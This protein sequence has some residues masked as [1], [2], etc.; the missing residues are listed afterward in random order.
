MMK[1]RMSELEGY[2]LN[3]PFYYREPLKYIFIKYVY[4][5]YR[6]IRI[7]SGCFFPLAEWQKKIWTL[8]KIAINSKS[9]AAKTTIGDKSSSPHFI[10]EYIEIM[11]LI[12][13]EHIELLPQKIKKFYNKN[14]KQ[15]VIDSFSLNINFFKV[16]NKGAASQQLGSFHIKENSSLFKYIS[17]V[18]F[19]IVN[20]SDSFCCLIVHAF[21]EKNLQEKINKLAVNSIDI[22]FRIAGYEHKKWFQFRKLSYEQV[23]GA[24]YKRQLL[25]EIVKDITWNVCKVIYKSIPDILF[26]SQK[27]LPPYICSICTNIDGNS[28]NEFWNSVGVNSYLCDYMQCYSACIAWRDK[29]APYFIRGERKDEEL[30][31]LNVYTAYN[32]SQTLCLCMIPD[33]IINLIRKNLTKYSKSITILKHKGVRKWLKLKVNMESTMFYLRRFIDEYTIEA[34]SWSFKEFK[35]IKRKN[36]LIYDIFNGI[37]SE[38]EATKSLYNIVS[39]IFKSNVDYRNAKSN[40]HLQKMALIIS[41]LSMFI[42]IMSIIISLLTNENSFE[43]IRKYWSYVEFF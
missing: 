15:G 6:K 42:A 16:F 25:D 24:T 39:E 43:F 9:N 23:S 21:L 12:P 8:D 20:I 5:I 11:E 38:I 32:I 27:T 1:K 4:I 22:Q 33:T 40:Y 13:K 19:S 14:C 30:N 35:S 36:P 7:K 34:N 17:D 29:D 10:V 31:A 2:A 28:N 26:Y 37:N 3:N 18:H 41:I